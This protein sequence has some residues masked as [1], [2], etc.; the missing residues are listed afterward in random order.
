MSETVEET[1][2]ADVRRWRQSQPV[3]PPLD[4]AVRQVVGRRRP[5]RRIGLAVAASVLV[6]AAGV[7]V[8]VVRSL[9]ASGPASSAAGG[10]PAA[11]VA[12]LAALARSAAAQNGDPHAT[13]EAV[14]TTNA[15]AERS[16][17]TG[18]DPGQ[19]GS[20]EVWVI[21]VRGHFR[22][23]SCFDLLPLTAVAEIIDLRA[24]QVYGFSVRMRPVDL[25][26]L[27]TVVPLPR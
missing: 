7:A 13:A 5:S 8:P 4:A 18:A 16:L 17:G 25:T 3:P 9:T 2:R 15:Q 20:T 6:V 1:L 27:G 12:R 22:C 23:P 10:P 11:V 21:Q 14:R 24:N 19:P 26:P